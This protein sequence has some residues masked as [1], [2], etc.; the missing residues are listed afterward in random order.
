[1]CSRDQLEWAVRKQRVAALA[2][3]HFLEKTDV[4][5]L[6]PTPDGKGVAAVKGRSRDGSDATE[7]ERL[8]HA[9]LVVDA[10]GH[11]STPRSGSRL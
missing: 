8:L 11:N 4:T 1:M 6:L 5:G 7:S 3:V 9:E 2:R 10:S